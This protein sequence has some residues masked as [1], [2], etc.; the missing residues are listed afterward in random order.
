MTIPTIAFGG[1]GVISVV[2]NLVPDLISKLVNFALNNDFQS[3]RE[4]HFK[5]SALFKVAFIESNPSPIKTAMNLVGMSA[6]D[7]RLPLCELE[8]ESLEKLKIV[9]NSMGLIK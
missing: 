9:L 6:G 5:L 7:C 3:A 4:L 8:K 2:S 1:R